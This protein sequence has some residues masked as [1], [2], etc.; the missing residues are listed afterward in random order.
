MTF[1]LSESGFQAKRLQDI[2]DETITDWKGK[3]GD[4]ID[5]DARRPAGNC[6]TNMRGAFLQ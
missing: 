3:F 2:S 4:A 6:I 1:G 5:L